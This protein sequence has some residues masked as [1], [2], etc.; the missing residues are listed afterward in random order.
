M[1]HIF[2]IYGP[3]ASGKTQ[4]TK[5]LRKDK[6]ILVIDDYIDDEVDIDNTLCAIQTTEASNIIIVTNKCPRHLL[7]EIGLANYDVTE[8]E[9]K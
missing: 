4:L 5:L 7:V 2:V 8:F 3:P 1:K 9:A 6:N